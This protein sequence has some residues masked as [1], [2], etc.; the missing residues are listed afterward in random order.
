MLERTEGIII[1][2]GLAP[3]SERVET[4]RLGM[5]YGFGHDS[6]FLRGSC[7]RSVMQAWRV[8]RVPLIVRFTI[9]DPDLA[10]ITVFHLA[11]AV[12]VSLLLVVAYH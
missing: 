8:A 3:R 7:V 11:N 6:P 2:S 4:N 10:V 12:L 1:T 5:E 9:A